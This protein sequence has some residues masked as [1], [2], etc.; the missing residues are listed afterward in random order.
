MS[1]R[2]FKVTLAGL[3]VLITAAAGQMKQQMLG[4]PAP[5]FDLPSVQG[6]SV[7]LESLRGKLVVIHFAASW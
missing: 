7:S 2:R 6:D 4:E 5:A 1:I 3:V